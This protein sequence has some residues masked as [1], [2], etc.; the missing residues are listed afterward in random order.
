MILGIS[1]FKKPAYDHFNMTV[2]KASWIIQL[3]DSTVDYSH[4]LNL[5]M[6][7]LHN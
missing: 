5:A 2:G 6:E 4:A 3:P 7:A 1:Y